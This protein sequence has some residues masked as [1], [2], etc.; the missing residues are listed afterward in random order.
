MARTMMRL[1][2]TPEDGTDPYELVVTSRDFMI[3]ERTGKNRTFQSFMENISA[4]GL[5]E[6]S[7]I[8]ARREGLFTGSLSEWQEAVFVNSVRPKPEDE[9]DEEPAEDPTR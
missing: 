5:Y 6:L 8:T 3:W 9:M 2:V 1:E 7:H 4:V